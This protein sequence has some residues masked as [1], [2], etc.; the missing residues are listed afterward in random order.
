MRAPELGSPCTF[1]KIRGMYH[2][3]QRKHWPFVFA[4]LWEVAF[5]TTHCRESTLNGGIGK[6]CKLSR[7]KAPIS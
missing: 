2:A 3:G 1:L 6:G 5:S 4:I 7:V